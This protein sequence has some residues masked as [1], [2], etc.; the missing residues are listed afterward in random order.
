MKRLTRSRS[1]R[2]T[3]WPRCG[4]HAGLPK[5]PMPRR[6]RKVDSQN[7][8]HT[9]AVLVAVLGRLAWFRARRGDIHEEIQE[10]DEANVKH[11]PGGAPVT[12]MIL[13]AFAPFDKLSVA[14]ELEVILEQV[15]VHYCCF[16]K[17]GFHVE[18][19]SRAGSC[20]RGR[21]SP[22]DGYGCS[23]FV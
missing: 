5:R 13:V 14:G 1:K 9:P 6:I 10:K 23:T 7:K 3:R 2:W 4:I 21:G 20:S 16:H 17:R 19:L 8:G 18:L 12:R 22:W 11:L 15:L